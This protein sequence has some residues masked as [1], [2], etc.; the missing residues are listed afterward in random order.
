MARR[1]TGLS[2]ARDVDTF[3]FFSRLDGCHVWKVV[4]VLLLFA[5]ESMRDSLISVYILCSQMKE[6][7][8]RRSLVWWSD[9][10][11]GLLDKWKASIR[12]LK[13]PFFRNVKLSH[14]NPNRPR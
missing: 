1:R 8:R 3:F 12:P 2:W 5:R 14:R 6:G 9:M 10:T 7:K 11:P 4:C 13:K